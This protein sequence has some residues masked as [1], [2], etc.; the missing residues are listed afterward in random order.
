[1]FRQLLAD[2]LVSA[3]SERPDGPGRPRVVYRPAV[4]R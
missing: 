3:E 1:M 2:Q 4:P